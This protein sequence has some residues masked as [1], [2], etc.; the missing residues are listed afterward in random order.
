VQIKESLLSCSTKESI[1][2]VFNKFGISDFSLKTIFLRQTMQVQEV[3]DVPN[4]QSLPD[5]D[6]YDEDNYY[7]EQEIFFD[8]KWRDLV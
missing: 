1:D 8:G 5:E 4:G 3:F 6:D 2:A 7:E